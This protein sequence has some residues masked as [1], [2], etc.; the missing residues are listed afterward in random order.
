MPGSFETSH[1]LDLIKWQRRGDLLPQL[2]VEPVLLEPID[3][4]LLALLL[5]PPPFQVQGDLE[6]LDYQISVGLA[7]LRRVPGRFR[8]LPFS[9]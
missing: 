5:K 1:L 6:N 4:R 9:Q 3:L 2:A 7:E 8:G